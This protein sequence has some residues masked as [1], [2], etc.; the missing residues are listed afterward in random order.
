[1]ASSRRTYDT[2]VIT[3]RTVFA[4]NVVNSNIPALRVLT[5][6]G[7]GGTYWAIPSSLG[8]NPA[9]NEIVT[10][11]GTY[12]ADL[13]YNKFRLLAGEGIGMVNGPAG[14]N[15]TTLY[16]QAF[17]TVDVSG[18]NSFYAFKNNT[19]TPFI[20]FATTGPI[21]VRSDP[22]TNTLFIDGPY[23]VLSSGQFCFTQLKVTPQTS[24]IT[25]SVQGW[26]GDF[27]T[28]N[29]PSTLVRFAG[30]N[31]IQLSTNVTTNSVFFTISTFTSKGYLDTSTIAAVAYPNAISTVSS[32]Y[33]LNSVFDSTISGISSVGGFNF[34]S[35]VSSIN[36]LAMSTGSN[37]YTLTGLINE[38]ADINELLYEIGLVNT[39]IIS[40]TFGEDTQ[41][42]STTAGLL[43]TGV[44]GGI[45][46]NQL[47][48]TTHGT[49]NQLISSIAGV[50]TG[51]SSGPIPFL[52]SFTVSTGALFTSSLQSSTI[53]NTGTL[54]THSLVVYGPS[55]LTVQG[56]SYFQNTLSSYSIVSDRVGLLDSSSG[57]SLFITATNGS[58]NFDG[59]TA[60]NQTILTSTV[61]GI[62]TIETV[63]LKST[64]VGL[65][66]YG[67]LSSLTGFQASTGFLQTSTVL[68]LDIFT[69]DKNTLYV[70]GQTLL[71]NGNFITGGAGG[72]GG[73]GVSKILA[74]ADIS[75]NPVAGI[76]DVTITNTGP[77][78]NNLISTTFGIDTQLISTTFGINRSLLSTNFNT[79][80]TSQLVST[81][82]GFNTFLISTTFGS[83]N[84][85]LS[86]I[87]G[88][89]T[90]LISTT[91]GIFA[92]GG[93]TSNQLISTTFGSDNQLIS[94]TFGSDN[95]LISTS[96]GSDNQLISTTFGL[97]SGTGGG[98]AQ[99]TD[100]NIASTL[101]YSP[102]FSSIKIGFNAGFTA[103]GNNS[104]AIGANAG[105]LN[106]AAS[107]IV[108]S[109]LGDP[110]NAANLG[111]F[112]APLRDVT[113]TQNFL[114]GYN[115][116]N[117]EMGTVRAP[118]V[119][120]VVSTLGNEDATLFQVDL[121]K[122]FLFTQD[123]A[124]RNI[125]FPT[126]QD[127]WNC[128]I[129]NMPASAN[130]FTL[131]TT[132]TAVIAP[133]VTTT[134]VCDGVSFYSL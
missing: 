19:L 34:S 9:F 35:V 31:D 112:M 68:L 67:Y 89:D 72:G 2:D 103:Q 109:A 78:S 70:S 5:A 25:S 61:F 43:A 100:S 33:T 111:V 79:V 106:Q 130:A 114:V 8:E 58:L 24:T 107:S 98:G 64:V 48:S 7:T 51:G 69:N 29:T 18:E 21:Q 6:D 49:D 105:Y 15:Q 4:K 99:V 123:N 113:T 83:D 27:L 88:S 13:S 39:R 10:S 74:G 133:G 41:L 76:G 22:A 84:Q 66:T 104:I 30:V 85:L 28:A 38:K 90:Q 124:S 11:A 32:L 77:N 81:G 56:L 119:S 128:V 110:L 134:V 44:G 26:G 37:F 46:S 16:A 17:N 92:R 86:S 94:T 75:I 52:S 125:I 42:I 122:Y 14:S 108:I 95:Q 23:G 20:N 36:A 12:T 71:L 87:F 62:N 91:A 127:G 1:M 54:S 117:Y 3:L 55:T 45:T 101:Q 73:G 120:V 82:V 129:K 96:F 93:I 121:G 116:T 126:A 132:T 97:A 50:G 60:T 40:S 131:N 57:N 118:K 80:Q 102:Y 53:L 63:N 65:G 115:S 59:A 47:I